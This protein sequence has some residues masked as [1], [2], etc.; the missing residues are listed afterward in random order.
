MT[1]PKLKFGK[2]V[3]IR[4][5]SLVE[6]KPKIVSTSGLP[7]SAKFKVVSDVNAWA[8]RLHFCPV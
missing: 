4:G 5:Y 8:K 3:S 2:T 7:R 6:T 1:K